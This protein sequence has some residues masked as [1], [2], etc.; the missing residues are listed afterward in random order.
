MLLT[1][2]S[3]SAAKTTGS[4]AFVGRLQRGLSQ[5]LPTLDRRGFLRRSGLGIGVGL[6]ATQLTLVKK[7]QARALS[8]ICLS[9]IS[10]N[11]QYTHSFSFIP[12]LIYL[13]SP[14]KESLSL[15]L[16]TPTFRP[17]L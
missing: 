12:T 7:A 4:S 2:K 17:H 9:L 5:A 11:V 14:Q 6:A 3:D 13:K 1:R 10:G 16:F 8:T 15:N